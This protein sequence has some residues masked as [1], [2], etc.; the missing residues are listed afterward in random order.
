MVKVLTPEWF[1]RSALEV[2]PD[3]VGCTL[4][5]RLGDGRTLRGTIVETEAYQ[6]GDPACH[7]YRKKTKRNAIMFG[8]AGYVYVYLIYGMYH[9][10]NFV[11]DRDGFAS[12]VLIRA[13]QMEQVDPI[14]LKMLNAKLKA[15]EKPDRVAAGPGKLCR[16]MDI[17][18]ELYGTTLTTD[19]PLWVEARVKPEIELIQ[20][21]RIGLTQGQDLPWRWYLK[22]CTAISKPG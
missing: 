10:L 13:L 5:R 22:D 1:S 3:L 21:T 16:V 7:A 20:T 15:K 6:E 9:C 17:N 19:S 18:L 14:M 8:P 12:A 2:A 11:T 4:V